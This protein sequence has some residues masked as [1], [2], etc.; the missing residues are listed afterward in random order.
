MKGGTKIHIVGSNFPN[1]D[2]ITC[3]F[4]G[5]KVKAHRESNN[6]LTCDA[7]KTNKSG[8]VD[9]SVQVFEGL[10]SAS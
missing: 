3:T 5:K 7:P 10:D 4:G 1:A 9:F 2:N 6:E 8:D